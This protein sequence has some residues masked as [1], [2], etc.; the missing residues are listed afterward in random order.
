MNLIIGTYAIYLIISLF[1]TTW[2]GHSLHRFGYPFLLE[3]FKEERLAQS[4]NN[5][6]LVGFYLV[7]I[8]YILIVLKEGQTAINLKEVFDIISIKVGLIASILAAMHFFNLAIFSW[9]RQRRMLR[10]KINR[11]DFEFTDTRV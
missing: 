3:A 5:L 6:L 1:L 7:N 10:E 4:V 11:I 8:A 9:W 2:V